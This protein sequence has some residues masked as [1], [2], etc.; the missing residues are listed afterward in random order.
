MATHTMNASSTR[1]ANV[2]A[3]HLVSSENVPPPSSPPSAPSLDEPN[4]AY[5]GPLHGLVVV[6]LTQ[7]VSGPAATQLLADQG[8]DVI[9]VEPPAGATSER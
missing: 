3:K 2:L 1:R 4:L 6:D 9:K 5:E 7:M 8:A